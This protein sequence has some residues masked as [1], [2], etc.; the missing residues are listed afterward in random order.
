MTFELF[1][2]NLKTQRHNSRIR[3]REVKR[4]EKIKWKR[5]EGRREERR[6]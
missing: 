4:K 5:K 1:L 2:L 3:L 6:R